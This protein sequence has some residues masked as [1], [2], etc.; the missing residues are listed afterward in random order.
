MLLGFCAYTGL[1][2]AAVGDVE[3]HNKNKDGIDG[4]GA[5]NYYYT[6]N[7]N[8]GPQTAWTGAF[9]PNDYRTLT[10]G[11]FGNQSGNLYI[12]SCNVHQRDCNQ[13]SNWKTLSYP[14]ISGYVPTHPEK[15]IWCWDSSAQGMGCQVQP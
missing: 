1:A 6:I 11:A 3:T 8:T 12:H 4:I 2:F 13:A 15:K 10:A 14:V 5:V 9:L 7:S